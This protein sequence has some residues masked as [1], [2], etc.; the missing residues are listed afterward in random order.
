MP[1]YTETA[2][3]IL[4][5]AILLL[6][7]LP[8]V[9]LSGFNSGAAYADGGPDLIV[10]EITLSPAEPA[11]D[12]SVTITVTLKNQ[13]TAAAGQNYLVCYA[14]SAILATVPVNALEA[15]T[16]TTATFTWKT[17]PGSHTIK[18][19]ADSTGIVAETNETNN[20]KTY[21]FTTRA[22]DL[23]VQSINWSPSSPS[24]GDTV[25]FSVV[26][27]NQGNATSR[28]TKLNFYI[29]G[30]SRGI[31]DVSAISP[32]GTVTK[33]YSWVTLPGQHTLKASVD[34]AN[35]IRESNDNNNDYTVTYT[36]S[37]PDLVIDKIVWSPQ[38]PS[39][40][41]IVSINATVKN[42]G[43]GRADICTLVFIIDGELRSNLT[44]NAL[45]AG[46]SVNI[47]YNW[48]VISEKHEVKTI[49]DYLQNVAE[50]DETNNEKTATIST[51][52]PDL[53]VSSITWSPVNAAVG[54]TVTFTATI[55]NVGSGR[56][57]KTRA[58]WYIDGGI[59]ISPDIP[60]I[61]A[62]SETT[63]TYNWAA[64]AGSHAISIAI[65]TDNALVETTKENNK[66]TVNIAIVP[67]DLVIPDI[68][69]SPVNFSIDDTVTFTVTVKNQGGGRAEPSYLAAYLDGMLLGTESIDRIDSGASVN[70]TFTWKALN[71]RHTLKAIADY[72]RYLIEDNENNNES[73]VTVA[74]NMPDLAVD[75]VTWS[76]AEIR[77]GSEIT[78][79]ISIKNL[80]T[81]NAGPSRVAYYTDG[82]VAGYIDIGQLDAGASVKVH[83]LWSAA[84]GLH[85]IDVV[86]DSTNQILELDEAN[87]AKTVSIPPPDLIVSG[88][89]WT[90]SGATT[91]DN[92]TLTATIRNQGNSRS[93]I[94]QVTCY[95]DGLLIGTKDLPEINI[96]GS[97]TST[98]AWVAVAGK[99]KVKVTADVNN[100]VTESDETNND[101][102]VDFSTLTPDLTIPDISWLMENPL[103]DDKVSL[104][105]TVKNQGTG[106]AGASRLTYVVDNLP[107]FNENIASIPAGGTVT[108]TFY[109]YVKA[110]AH[111]VSATIDSNKKIA[112]LDENNNTKALA[113]NTIAPDFNLKSIS[114]LPSIPVSG[115]NVTI[116]VKVENR[117]RIKA[118]DTKLS[119]TI[120]G[121]P[122]GSAD[123]K[124]LDMGAVVSQ[125]FNWKAVAGSHEIIASADPDNLIPESNEA[126]NSISRKISI[127]K[128]AATVAPTVKPTTVSKASTASKGF[129]ASSWWLFLIMAALLSGGAFAVMIKS[130]KKG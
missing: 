105:I 28:T 124:Q 25:V 41:D 83:Y 50:S 94:A 12:D 103:T 82:A 24:R 1:A 58:T 112:E 26:V 15:G 77:A 116:T 45:E 74:P 30:A 90:P 27:K 86:A 110:G 106:T 96:A 20:T 5:I 118:P 71:G 73:S 76:P 48:T 85:T 126:N 23:I 2:K 115:D 10:Q 59:V 80:G 97:A 17:E 111:T 46:A 123:I 56:S 35:N 13:G 119:L 93:Q 63:L 40:N 55:K 70:R 91:G 14:D 120:D 38:N 52:A 89:T 99:H 130:M 29:D 57:E 113:F 104:T 75:T 32:G 8:G 11:I 39:K 101:K 47:T 51:L 4:T 16:M 108:F 84:A 107:A 68:S 9:T 102:E 67:P 53:T 7:F 79:D 54:D 95:V 43:S 33:T 88:I 36:T 65:D 121:S 21:S 109:Q 114:I 22:I 42:Q 125:D 100:R 122:A 18:A 128:P 44:V 37:P 61:N 19:T 87:N 69:W 78:F 66:L 62:G 34:E 64:P 72:N 129:M 60:E 127:E 98:F 81:L 3:K 117:G 49:V 31:Q 6:T 92:V